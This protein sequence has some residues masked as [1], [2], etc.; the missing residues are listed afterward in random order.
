MGWPIVSLHAVHVLGLLLL[1]ASL[2][3]I[4]AGGGLCKLMSDKIAL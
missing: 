1:L 4:F 3:N 2:G